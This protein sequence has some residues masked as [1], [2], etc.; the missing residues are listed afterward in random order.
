MNQAAFGVQN[1]HSLENKGRTFPHLF[2]PFQQLHY[3]TSNQITAKGQDQLLNFLG[4]THKHSL[5]YQDFLKNKSFKMPT[6][7][8]D[9]SILK[10][11]P[12]VD[13]NNYINAYELPMLVPFYE[14]SSQIV[15]SSTSGTTGEPSFFPRGEF[16]DA[17]YEY[18]LEVLINHYFE[19]LRK[20]TLVVNAFGMGIW[21]AGIFTYKTLHNLSVKGYN[22]TIAPTGI[23]ASMV[24]LT[25]KKLRQYYDQILLIGYPPHIKDFIEEFEKYDIDLSDKHVSVLTAAELYS[26]SYREYMQEKL[27]IPE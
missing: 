6:E 11:I 3:L 15:Y 18:I 12:P 4:Y 20:P 25:V 14:F 13:K 7:I 9:I 27:G 23:D 17:Q 22:L 8:S 24:G 19:Y 2:L 1:V 21:I 10:D 26:E 5:G 16:Q